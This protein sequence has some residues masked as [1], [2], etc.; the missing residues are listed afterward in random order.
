MQV[1]SQEEFDYKKTLADLG[2]AIA[3][4]RGELSLIEAEKEKLISKHEGE[5][6]IR[7]QEVLEA[8]KA[9][10]M[11]A[12]AHREELLGYQSDLTAYADELVH[13]REKTEE[14]IA[15]FERQSA[16]VMDQLKAKAKEIEVMATENRE[17]KEKL[18]L[19]RNIVKGREIAVKEEYR[20][21]ASQR[22]TLQA[23]FEEGRKKGI[24]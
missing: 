5:A 22:A 23:A 14:N 9:A 19:E 4:A 16:E 10:L 12:K 24:L 6:L 15:S 21:I 7:V 8:S 13:L 18:H 1:L 2:V 17:E 20:K 11:E 3:K